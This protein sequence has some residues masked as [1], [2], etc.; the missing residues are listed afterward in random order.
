M[1]RLLPIEIPGGWYHVVTRAADDRMIFADT[2]ACDQF[3]DRL[4]QLPE[5]FEIRIHA[6]I[7]M[8]NHYH[9][10]IETLCAN[11]SESIRWLNA[12]YSKYRRNNPAA[13]LFERA[14]TPTLHDSK[15]GAL[16]INRYIH[17]NPVR[18]GAVGIPPA[19]EEDPKAAFA[20]ASHNSVKARIKALSHSWSSYDVYVAQKGPA[21]AIWR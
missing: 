2:A 1:G 14:F 7:L 9:L 8:R 11:L 21:R 19:T 4:S 13:S 3:L 17:L 16:T 18:A 12:A 6:Y 10:Q 15:T 20:Q 5:R